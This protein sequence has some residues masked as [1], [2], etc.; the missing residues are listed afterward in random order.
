MD[1]VDH[2]PDA[3]NFV[4]GVA[5]SVANLFLQRIANSVFEKVRHLRHE[6]R[7]NPRQVTR[8][9]DTCLGWSNLRDVEPGNKLI[10]P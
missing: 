2:F 3:I 4:E 9:G 10:S 5:D 6:I 8:P 1:V 7:R